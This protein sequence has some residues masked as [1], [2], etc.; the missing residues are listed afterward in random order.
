MVLVLVHRDVLVLDRGGIKDVVGHVRRVAFD[1][2]VAR[3][4]VGPVHCLAEGE[5][6]VSAQIHAQ[7]LMAELA[8][9]LRVPPD[10]RRLYGRAE[11][12][13][14]RPSPNHGGWES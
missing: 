7:I 9:I 11:R 8:L 1:S 12:C 4:G 14:P 6:T 2:E 5:P 3:I 13:T 10:L